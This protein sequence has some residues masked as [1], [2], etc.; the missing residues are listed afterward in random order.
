[1][2]EAGAK[3]R[4]AETWLNTILG[5]WKRRIMEEVA[6]KISRQA[7]SQDEY[8][9]SLG[10][11]LDRFSNKVEQSFKNVARSFDKVNSR[12]D[13]MDTRLGN[14]EA[15]TKDIKETLSR[16]EAKL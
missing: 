1:M 8:D 7:K 13:N 5:K 15:D 12:L 6:G 14:I 2:A 10:R 16:M 9:Q 11:K 3:R 4:K